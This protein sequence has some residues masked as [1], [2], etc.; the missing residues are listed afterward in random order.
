MGQSFRGVPRPVIQLPDGGDRRTDERDGE[1]DRNCRQDKTRGH[2]ALPSI[3][4][5]AVLFSDGRLGFNGRAA[6]GHPE[7]PLGD[8]LLRR[9]QTVI[10]WTRYPEGM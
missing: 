2:E 7:V 4:R 3:R 5:P 10:T 9:N 6:R 8:L 1:R